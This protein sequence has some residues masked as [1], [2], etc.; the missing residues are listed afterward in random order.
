MIGLLSSITF[1]SSAIGYLNAYPTESSRK[2]IA[3]AFNSNTGIKAL[4]GKPENIDTI[5][6]FTAW[7][8]LGAGS[9]N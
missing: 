9:N 5:A 6:G 8:S 7:R 4:I 1:V 2:L 3:L